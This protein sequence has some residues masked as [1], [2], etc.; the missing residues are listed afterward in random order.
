MAGKLATFLLDLRS[1][2]RAARVDVIK[3]LRA[4]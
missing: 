2:A 3:A 4:D 1:A